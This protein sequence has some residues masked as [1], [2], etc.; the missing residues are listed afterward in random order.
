MKKEPIFGPGA[1]D[2]LYWLVPFVVS[3]IVAS[4]LFG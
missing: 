3:V 1:V 2:A 4:W